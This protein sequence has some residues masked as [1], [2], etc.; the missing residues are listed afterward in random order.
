MKETH[1][2]YRSSIE[3]F[4]EGFRF[5]ESRVAFMYALLLLS[6]Y[7]IASMATLSFGGSLET[8]SYVA[9][10]FILLSLI[11]F[12]RVAVT[13]ERDIIP[14]YAYKE[15]LFSRFWKLLVYDVLLIA[16]GFPLLTFIA[17]IPGIVAFGGV[18]GLLLVSIVSVVS[19][20]LTLYVYFGISLTGAVIA[21]KNKSILESVKVSWV[22][23][24]NHRFYV[25]KVFLVFLGILIGAGILSGLATLSG[26]SVVEHVFLIIVS[27]FGQV[28]L[29]STYVKMYEELV[30]S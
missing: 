23:V 19:F 14:T 4:K 28:L 21:D 1:E 27:T 16:A 3:T 8:S 5:F 30:P 18:L 29:T 17:F 10:P 12:I 26:S 9:M 2:T 24:E 13:D 15:R 22:H 20:I 11:V 25:L 6:I 7:F